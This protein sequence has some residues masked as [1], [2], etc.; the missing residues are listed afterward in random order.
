MLAEALFPGAILVI[1]PYPQ[2]DALAVGPGADVEPLDLLLTGPQRD[3]LPGRHH[4]ARELVPAGADDQVAGRAEALVAD[5][6]AQ[7]GPGVAYQAPNSH[8]A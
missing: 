5:D 8:P 1:R 6:E 2:W 4:L 3:D 7:A